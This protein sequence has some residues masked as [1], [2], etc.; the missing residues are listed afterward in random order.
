M[1]KGVKKGNI[2]EAKG[3]SDVDEFVITLLYLR[4]ELILSNHLYL[5]IELIP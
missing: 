2:D 5:R 4:I 3:Q 1:C